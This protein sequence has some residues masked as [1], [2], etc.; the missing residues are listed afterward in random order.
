MSENKGKFVVVEGGEGSGKSSIVKNLRQYY[1]DAL[2]INDPYSYTPETKIIRD[3]VLNGK[4]DLSPQAELL[5]YTACRAELVHKKIIPALD[6]GRLVICDRFIVSTFVYQGVIKGF[7]V[8]L[9]KQLHSDF[10]N[11][12]MPDILFLCDVDAK[13]GIGRSISRLSNEEIHESRWEDMGI[14]IHGEINSAYRTECLKFI[15]S[16]V[17]DSNNDSIEEMTQEAKNYI[18]RLV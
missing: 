13:T 3:L 14:R 7:D 11:Y 18:D 5:L 9:I 17:L 10:C 8:D 16:Y 15:N 6:A 4:Y 2:V 1:T 12:I